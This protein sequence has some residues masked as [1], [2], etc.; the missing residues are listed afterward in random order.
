[1]SFFPK[2]SIIVLHWNRF[3]ETSECLKSLL[4]IDY[5]HYDVIVVDNH[6]TDNSY[7][8]L[9][10]AFP[11]VHFM[12]NEWNLGFAEG[13]N[14]GI[15]AALEKGADYI[16]LLNNDTVVDRLLLRTLIQ[17]AEAHPTAGVFGAKIYYYNE[18]TT[19]WYAGGNVHLKSLRCYH[20][21]CT[22]SD[23]EKKREEIE[24]TG[25]ACGC[26]LMVK[27]EVV[28]TCGLMDPRFFLLWEEIDWCWRI[29]RA[30]YKCLFVPQ[31]KVW[32]KISTSFEGGHRGA[33]WEYFYARNRLL[34]LE[35]HYSLKERVR[36][37]SK[38]FI[39]DI[40]KLFISSLN[41]KASKEIRRCHLAAL[42]GI[43]DYC[44]RRFGPSS[45][46]H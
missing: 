38:T 23:L 36:F 32:H 17:A 5:P 46:F 37:Y 24:E 3:Q 19:I 10:L 22:E 41:F 13:N 2:V 33:L 15:V 43:K 25:Y 14:R 1:M 11:T 4:S 9:M 21:G 30:G 6:S 29:R 7:S 39:K 26:A 8:A 27:R 16:L 34:F 28:Q 40:L 31:A 12:Q 18:P 44:L 45:R 20:T 35:R 42:S